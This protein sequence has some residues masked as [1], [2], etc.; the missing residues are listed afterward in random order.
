MKECSHYETVAASQ[1]GQVMGKNGSA[2]DLLGYVLIVPA[3]TAPGAVQIKD[4]GGSAITIYTGGTVGADLT[5]IRI[6]LFQRSKAG[7]WTIVTGA[8]LSC[9]VGGVFND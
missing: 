5:P 1:A 6:E 7:A 8:N 2:G 3:T 4:G 9:L